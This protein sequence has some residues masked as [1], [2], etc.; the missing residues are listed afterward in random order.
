MVRSRA[1]GGGA[2]LGGRILQ[3]HEHG[4]GMQE[5]SRVEHRRSEVVGVRVDALIAGT[6]HARHCG[7][8]DDGGVRSQNALNRLLDL[9][10]RADLVQ[11]LCD[12]GVVMSTQPQRQPTD[13]VPELFMPRQGVAHFISGLQ[14]GAQ[15]G[16]R[17]L[18]ENVLEDDRAVLHHDIRGLRSRLLLRDDQVAR[19]VRGDILR[20]AL[21]IVVREVEVELAVVA[22]VIR[23]AATVRL[24]ERLDGALVHMLQQMGRKQHA[25]R[26]QQRNVKQHPS[27]GPAERGDSLLAP[28]RNCASRA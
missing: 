24:H 15:I 22:F 2:H 16:G 19:I 27:Q 28:C 11:R 25:E 6:M 10:M 9:G 12:D 4:V 14:V 8:L 20:I 21:T 18:R 13:L 17:L 23:L 3:R 1:H 26:S 7:D 5:I